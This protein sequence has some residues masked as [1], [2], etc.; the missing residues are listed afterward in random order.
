[1]LVYVCVYV[2]EYTLYKCV[3]GFMRVF[4]MTPFEKLHSV[5]IACDLVDQYDKH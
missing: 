3:V 4:T 2:Y 5:F 1:M